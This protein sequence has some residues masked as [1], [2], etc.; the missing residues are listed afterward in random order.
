MPSQITFCPCH[1]CQKTAKNSGLNTMQLMASIAAPTKARM[2]RDELCL[3]LA[4]CSM[5]EILVQAGGLLHSGTWRMFRN[6]NSC[7]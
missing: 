2:Y 6:H 7:Y 3:A 1:K 4:L 5:G